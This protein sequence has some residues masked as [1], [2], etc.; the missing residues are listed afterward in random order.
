MRHGRSVGC[1]AADRGCAPGPGCLRSTTIVPPPVP[2]DRL[3][4]GQHLDAL[5]LGRLLEQ[6]VGPVEEGT[7]NLAVEV[8]LSALLALEGVEDAEG[9]GADLKGVLVQLQAVSLRLDVLQIRRVERLVVETAPV[10]SIPLDS[11]R[12]LDSPDSGRGRSK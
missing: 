6:L 9:G 10:L 5:D 12:F 8:R 2:A 3:L 11:G 7:R 4:R 1:V